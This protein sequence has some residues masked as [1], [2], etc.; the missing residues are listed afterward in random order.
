[1]ASEKVEALT[2]EDIIRAAQNFR[3]TRQM[4][5]WTTIVQGRELPARPLILEAAGVAPN[6]PTNSHQAIAKLKSLGFETRY[7]GKSV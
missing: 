5:K 1:M 7:G 2:K 6:D 4:P 3:W